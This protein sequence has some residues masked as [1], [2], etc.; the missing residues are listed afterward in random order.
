MEALDILDISYEKY[1]F[2]A[3]SIPLNLKK[4]VRENNLPC[5]FFKFLIS[6]NS[7]IP[8]SSNKGLNKSNNHT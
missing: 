8:H 1:A 7:I 3:F 5:E 2:S 6:Q 4:C